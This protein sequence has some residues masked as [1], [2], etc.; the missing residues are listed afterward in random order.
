MLPYEADVL[1]VVP[2][3]SATNLP[4]SRLNFIVQME[5][6]ESFCC[7]RQL[8]ALPFSVQ[9]D[10]RAAA[11]ILGLVVASVHAH[12]GGVVG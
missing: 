6:M 11:C 8:R 4:L 5:F 9:L 2:P 7:H 3:L 12:A 1:R 10:K